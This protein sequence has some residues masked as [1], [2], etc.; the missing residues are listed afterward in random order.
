MKDF[1]A[2]QVING[3]WGQ[4]WYDGEYMAELK[5]FKAEVNYKKTAS[6]TA[7]TAGLP[8]YFRQSGR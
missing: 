4:I 7:T 5:A 8:E 3:T 2:N 6:A 1:N